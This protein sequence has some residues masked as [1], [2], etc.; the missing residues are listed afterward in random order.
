MP[1]NISLNPKEK[2]NIDKNKITFVKDFCKI[3]T[4]YDFNLLTSFI[5][6]CEVPVLIK[7]N[8]EFLKT[9]VQLRNLQ[10]RFPDF[11]FIQSFLY[12]VFNYCLDKRDGCDIFFS[13]KSSAGISHVDEEDVFIIGL[14][15]IIV[16]K[17][18]GK[19]TDYFEIHKGDLIY[20]PKGVPHKVIGLSP[21]IILSVGFHGNRQITNKEL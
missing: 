5:E 20:I 10:D 2:E 21:R 18:F 9:V 11:K 16:Y 13:L 3:E 4:K 19:N 7:N 14:N 17:T 15:G 12:Q 6:E 1:L 8:N